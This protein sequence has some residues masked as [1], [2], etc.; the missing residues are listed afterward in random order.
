MGF[1]FYNLEIF[2]QK[3]LLVDINFYQNNITLITDYVAEDMNKYLQEGLQVDL[4]VEAMKEAVSRNK[5][6]WKYVTGILKDCINNKVQTAEQFRI[7]QE[8]FKINK[9]KPT[10]NKKTEEKIEY[11]EVEF[12][13]E[14]EY[15]KKILEKG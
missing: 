12:T 9:T 1:D 10:K 3:H 6:N 2:A 5:R 7:K 14:E 11:E 15:K 13:N 4:I 8:E